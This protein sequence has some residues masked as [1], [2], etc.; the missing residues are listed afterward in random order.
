MDEVLLATRERARSAGCE[1]RGPPRRR[2]SPL[3]PRLPGADTPRYSRGPFVVTAHASANH[4]PGF[5]VGSIA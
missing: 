2:A 4:K 3:Q 1:K 5:S